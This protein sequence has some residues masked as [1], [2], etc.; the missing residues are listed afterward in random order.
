MSN[1]GFGDGRP[2]AGPFAILTLGEL[3]S[4]EV[5][6]DAQRGP[7]PRAALLV[8]AI[9]AAHSRGRQ[10]GW[11]MPVSTLGTLGGLSRASVFRALAELESRGLVER[12][13]QPHP[14]GGR[15]SSRYFL[16]PPPS[17]ALETSQNRPSDEQGP[18]ASYPQAGGAPSQGCDHPPSQ[19]CDH[20]P[21][22]GCDPKQTVSK[23]TENS[24]TPPLAPPDGGEPPPAPPTGGRDG[25]ISALV[26]GLRAYHHHLIRLGET[27]RP[28]D[29]EPRTV[30]AWVSHY[31]HG[32]GA[33][34]AGL[35]HRPTPPATGLRQK[36]IVEGLRLW[37]LEVAQLPLLKG[38]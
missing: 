27:P 16:T 29:Y 22:Q 6:G 17:L 19:G 38:T 24:Q 9:L 2:W 15:G 34:Y 23:Q 30:R 21:S 13:Y 4:P 12:R 1:R 8:W 14:R 37:H 3:T 31:R 28:S 7:L 35:G 32:S 26:D 18:A 5:V 36:D 25:R 33:W 20:P 10:N 11:S